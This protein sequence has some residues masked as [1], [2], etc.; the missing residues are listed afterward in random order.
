MFRLSKIVLFRQIHILRAYF[1]KT[2][3]IHFARPQIS[4]S[5]H[6]LPF[7]AMKMLIAPTA[8]DLTVALVNKVSMETAQ[9]AKVNE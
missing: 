2:L 4:T 7:R 9:S 6:W 5:V 1:F 8:K 3:R